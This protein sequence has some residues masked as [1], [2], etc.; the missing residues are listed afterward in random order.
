M[1]QRL[2]LCTD[3]LFGKW[4][5]LLLWPICF[6]VSLLWLL[7]GRH[8]IR[9]YCQ[10]SISQFWGWGQQAAIGSS[11]RLLPFG[12][13][14]VEGTGFLGLTLSRQEEHEETEPGNSAP[15]WDHSL[16]A[17]QGLL[18]VV[19]NSHFQWTKALRSAG[20][21]CFGGHLTDPNS[22][23]F[24]RCQMQWTCQQRHKHVWIITRLKKK[25][26]I[27]MEIDCRFFSPVI[28]KSTTFKLRITP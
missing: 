20:L 1:H 4:E 8:R 26:R 21:P 27:W 23:D 24:A 13:T 11:W 10:M 3:L 5:V 17:E 15:C 9:V 7:A 25:L 12:M 6:S 22:K 28:P 2:F 14:H 18:G 16:C 19:F